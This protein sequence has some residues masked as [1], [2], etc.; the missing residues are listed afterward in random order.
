MGDIE[1]H[2]PPDVV[3]VNLARMVV[4]SAARQAGMTEEKVEDLRIAVSEATTNAIVAH[5]REG[6]EEPV[7]LRFGEDGGGRFGVTVVDAGPGFE[8]V[9]PSAIHDRDWSLES[10]LGV[11]LIRGLTDEVTFLRDGGMAVSMHFVVD[12]EGDYA[13]A[14]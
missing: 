10:G 7:T 14:S 1:L 2:I 5:R 3:H 12:L 9:E 8:P 6:K 11:T 13:D 4:C